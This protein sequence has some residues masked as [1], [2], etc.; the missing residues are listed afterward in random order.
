MVIPANALDANPDLL[1]VMNGVIDL[2]TRTYREPS[3]DLYITKSCAVVYNPDAKCPQW[4]A[5]LKKFLPDDRRSYLARVAGYL[6]TGS[7]AEEKPFCYGAMGKTARPRCA[8]RS[9]ACWAIT[10]SR[11]RP[12]C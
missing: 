2:K 11:A 5:F 1:G 6:L 10:R 12:R 4:R 8:R 9:F 3:R 7:V